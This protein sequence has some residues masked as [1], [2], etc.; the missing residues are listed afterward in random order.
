[1]T[2]ADKHRMTMTMAGT[3]P[4]KRAFRRGQQAPRSEHR[5]HALAA[6]G[7]IRRFIITASQLF[8]K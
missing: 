6:Q 5:A 2:P 1:M 4:P 3:P 8:P 7:A